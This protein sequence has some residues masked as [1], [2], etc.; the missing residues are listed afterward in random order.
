MRTLEQSRKP[1]L[2]IPGSREAATI[3]NFR[4][5]L[6]RRKQESAA[7]PGAAQREGRKTVVIIDDNPH[8]LRAMCLALARES[9][10]LETAD[11]AESA[12]R[13]L[14]SCHPDLILLNAQIHAA[15]GTRLA[16]RLLADE[17]LAHVPFVALTEMAPDMHA[18]P[19]PGGQ[20]DGHIGKPIDAPD[21]P[22]QIRSFLESPWPPPPHQPAEPA[23][24][25]PRSQA[26][27]LVEA[28]EAGLPHSQFAPGTR[29][30]LHQLAE[31]VDGLQHPDLAGYFQH[32][33]RLSTAATSRARSR[34][35][36]LIR[37]CRELIHR[38]PDVA[39]GMAAL[40]A[41]YLEHRRAELDSLE[42]AL[43]N[44]DFAALRKAGHNLKGTG[45][46]YG[47]AELTEIGEAIGA[48]AKAFDA[49][50]VEALL[51]Q[52][53]SYIS[54]ARPSPPAAAAL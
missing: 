24:A 12:I 31:A 10:C 20:F 48:A 35:Q 7:S 30:G 45:A 17:E 54:V 49:A 32:A 3:R 22:R 27:T 18:Q 50:A 23:T 15:D 16:R 1:A 14:S 2:R 41:R 47:F 53:E 40:R 39:P 28:I 43:K 25:D 6:E 26:A 44:G 46:A 38:N 8:D 37:L 13:I 19:Q 29:T 21:L 36:S 34:F 4:A 9:Y 52:I 33:E 42:L 11:T 5:I 51:D